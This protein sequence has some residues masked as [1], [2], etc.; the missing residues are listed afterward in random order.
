MLHPGSNIVISDEPK[1]PHMMTF[2]GLAVHE[3]IFLA[4]SLDRQP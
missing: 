3:T 4:G 2:T 1:V